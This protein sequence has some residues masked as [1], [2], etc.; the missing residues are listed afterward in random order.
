VDVAGIFSLVAQSV[1]I[2][3][4]GILDPGGRSA[5]ASARRRNALGVEVAELLELES[6]LQRD[7]MVEAAADVL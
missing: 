3:T 5:R 4:T 7:G 2:A 1:Q 6:A